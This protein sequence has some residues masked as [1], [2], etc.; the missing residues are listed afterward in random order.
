MEKTIYEVSYILLPNLTS[1]EVTSNVKEISDLLTSNGAEMIAEE[2]PVLIDLAYPM[3][4]VVQ[5]QRHK[6]ESG[7]FGWFKF[8]IEKEGIE[9]VKKA[10][11]ESSVIVRHLLIKTVREN[12]FIAG[13]ITFRKDEAVKNPEFDSEEVENFESEE[14]KIEEDSVEGSKDSDADSGSNIDKSIDD[15][16]IA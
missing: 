5:T 7:F 2:F 15:L 9:K 1:D 8:A 4:K 16:V 12:T 6:V 14:V 11:E 3:T 13:K 10:L